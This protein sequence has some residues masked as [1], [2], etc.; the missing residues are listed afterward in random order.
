MLK[1]KCMII[2]YWFIHRYSLVRALKKNAFVFSDTVYVFSAQHVPHGQHS[3]LICL[4]D[5]YSFCTCIRFMSLPH[6]HRT[7]KLHLY[8]I[9]STNTRGFFH[10]YSTVIRAERRHSTLK[11]KSSRRKEKISLLS[12]SIYR[13]NRLLLVRCRF[14]R[15]YVYA[16]ERINSG[17]L[18][19][20]TNPPIT[21]TIIVIRWLLSLRAA[22]AS[23]K[24]MSIYLLFDLIIA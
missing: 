8:R 20:N 4:W 23:T 9:R 16:C 12:L 18:V 3:E 19:Q 2:D 15:A 24:T 11:M 5:L 10:A 13:L 22:Y 1:E 14:V 7:W 6:I 17:F 21:S